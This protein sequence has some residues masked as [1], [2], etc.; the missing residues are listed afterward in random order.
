MSARA[1]SRGEAYVPPP[2]VEPVFKGHTLSELEGMN[3]KDRRTAK[4]KMEAL[5]IE[6]LPAVGEKKKGKKRKGG[7]SE[8]EEKAL[9]SAAALKAVLDSAPAPLYGADELAAMNAKDR[10]SATKKMEAVERE[11]HEDGA[12]GVKSAKEEVERL[13]EVA[14]A[15]GEAAAAEMEE[16]ESKKKPKKAPRPLAL[17]LKDAKAALSAHRSTMVAPLHTE[18]ELEAM[19]AKDR[20]SMKKKMEAIAAES[21]GEDV[22][23]FREELATLERAVSTAAVL[24]AG[25]DEALDD[26]ELKGDAR[27]K[28]NPYIVFVG[29]LDFKTT[30]EALLAHI[31]SALED[32]KIAG[33]CTVRLLT[34]GQGD[35]KRSKGMG[36]VQT[37]TPENL[38]ELLKLH[39]T[40]LEGR[41]IN[42]ERTAGGSKDNDKRKQKL[43]QYK[44]NQTKLMGDTIGKIIQ[45]FRESGDLKEGELDDGVVGLMGRHTT[46]TVQQSLTEYVDMR[47]DE[48]LDNPSAY[49]TSIITRVSVEGVDASERERKKARE[50]DRKNKVEEK[51][52]GGGDRRKKREGGGG[53]GGGGDGGRKKGGEESGGGGGGGGGGGEVEVKLTLPGSSSAP[54]MKGVQ[55]TNVPSTS[56]D[57]K[58]S[59]PG[60]GEPFDMKTVFSRGASRRGR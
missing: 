24:A 46:A 28:V 42:V 47:G 51:E 33:T 18:E 23:K 58:L 35:K 57:I 40:T 37:T 55:M 14:V 43:A 54:T 38:Y 52:R 30:R 6:V 5:K 41:R 25:E 12:E 45:E 4:K 9:A 10:R 59:L 17:K 21:K 26:G 53:G 22:K 3:A 27:R 15:D 56:G 49:L 29:Q 2:P 7:G 8:L 16:K 31:K 39:K 32:P 19:N 50:A 36:F 44:E 20:R 48:K 11:A 13:R 60:N 1:S 34:D